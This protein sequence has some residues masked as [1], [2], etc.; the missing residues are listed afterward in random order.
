[1]LKELS[2]NQSKAEDSPAASEPAV[3]N[4]IS[5]KKEP[6]VSTKQKAFAQLELAEVYDMAKI[7]NGPEQL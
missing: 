1:M 7:F 5:P 6:Q 2:K 3:F 4:P